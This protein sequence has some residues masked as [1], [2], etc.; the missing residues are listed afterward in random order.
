MMGAL[1][2]WLASG[3]S[4]YSSTSPFN[5]ANCLYSPAL[6]DKPTLHRAHIH[7]KSRFEMVHILMVP[8]VIVLVHGQ[9]AI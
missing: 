2:V 5:V 6:Q 7:G 3:F 1:R 8:D 9:A 4:L